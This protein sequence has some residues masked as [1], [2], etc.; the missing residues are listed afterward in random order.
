MFS[1]KFF[2]GRALAA[3]FGALGLL[4]SSLHAQEVFPARPVNMVIPYPPGGLSDGIARSI[5]PSLERMLKQPVV[6]MNRGGAGGAIGAASVAKAEP[7]GYTI[8]FTLSGITTLTEQALVT[9]Q[10]PLFTLNQFKPLA[11]I[12]TDRLAIIVKGDSKFKTLNELIAAARAEPD[13]ISYASSGNY[14]TVHV[15]IEMFAEDAKIKLRHIPYNGGGPIL[16]AILGSQ[17]DFTMLP[18]SSIAT[19]VDSGKMR[20]LAV[21]GKDVFPQYPNAPTTAAAGLSFDYL[22]WTGIFAPADTPP[23]VLKKLRSSLRAAVDDPQFLA[24]LAKRGGNIA[25]LDAPE[26]EPF[27]AREVTILTK[28]IRRLGKLE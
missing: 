17:V 9:N 24:A 7:N 3:L 5:A 15:P 1:N 2:H 12:S 8:M 21:V 6:L 20:I 23:E 11:R 27:L 4:V 13:K 26:F 19:M 25:Y 18:V 16:T 10:T 22:P 28:V 14:G